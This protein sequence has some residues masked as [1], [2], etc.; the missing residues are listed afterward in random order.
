MTWHDFVGF[1]ETD[2]Q[3]GSYIP[4]TLFWEGCLAKDFDI[5][6]VFSEEHAA[7]IEEFKDQLLIVLINRLGGNITIPVAEIDATGGFLLSLNAVGSAF[8]FSISKKQ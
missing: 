3:R 2:S 5:A 7:L 1:R 6:D 8:N 4:R